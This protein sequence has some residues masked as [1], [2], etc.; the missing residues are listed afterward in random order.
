MDGTVLGVV[1]S[2][3]LIEGLEMKL[4][5]GHAVED[6]RAGR[7]VV[8]QGDRYRFFSMLT[9]VRLDATSRDIL[10]EPPAPDDEFRRKVLLGSCAYA[11]VKLRPM[12]MTPTDGDALDA[13]MLPVKTV[14][15]HFSVVRSATSADVD[16]VFGSEARPGFFEIGAPVDMADTPV[17]LSLERLVQRSNGIFGKS[18]TG[19]TFLTRLCLCGTIRGSAAVNL[20]FDMHSEYGWEGVQEDRDRTR[21][22][23]LKQ[24]F[25]SRV[26]I[27]TLD[28]ESS[29]RR[30]AAVDF[31]VRIPYSQV[32]VDD[33]TLLQRE[34]NLTATAAETAYLLVDAFG[35][36][37]LREFLPMGPEALKQFA[38][39]SGANILAL[40]AL[41]RKLLQLQRA[42]GDFL[43]PEVPA[44]DDAVDA[45]LR[46][47]GSGVHVVLEFGQ[48][49]RPL[50]YMLAANILTRRIHE[51]YVALSERAQRDGS[52]PPTPLVIT[53]EEAHKFLAPGLADQ[54]IFGTIAREM[55]KYGVTLLI[56]DQR[57]SGIDRE[58]LSQVG[59]R[60]VCQLD[61][62]ND[63]N[64]V[65]SGLPD[66]GGLRAVLASLESKQQ[67]LLL[68]HAVPMPIV[69][70]TRQYDDEAF[71]K[72]M[73]CEDP[74]ER[75][76]R[77]ERDRAHDFPA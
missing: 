51:Q 37:W 72:A 22:R 71:R 52:G 49:S 32:T 8:V 7:F 60:L 47:L 21:V 30:G 50:Q 76:A 34:L 45:M 69:V 35:R 65:M 14:P 25:G 17:C 66:A 27:F 68:G 43:L 18:G 73:G 28:R 55:R 41:K 33:I 62:E 9:D 4:A 70:R 10:L 74:A 24:Y 77:L 53:I 39:A 16:R 5:D 1:V 26:A 59:T 57:P 75:S 67:A 13:D 54:T 36:D 12:L 11:T 31:E 2:G 19:K 15:P 40:G 58:V 48:H 20:V 38:E 46:C 56:V 64:A 63:V 6:L 29:R 3:S 23:G 42:C 61:D 44:A